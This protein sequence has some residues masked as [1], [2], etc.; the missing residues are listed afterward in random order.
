[1]KIN[2]RQISES[3]LKM[4]DKGGVYHGITEIVK[5]DPYLDMEMR[6]ST[7]VIVYYRGGKLLTID[8]E[9][10]LIGLDHNYYLADEDGIITPCIDNIFD[11]VSKAKFIIDKHE[12]VKPK[13]IEKEYQQ[14]V[15]Y[16]NNLSG[17]ANKTEY[18]IVDIEWEDSANLEGRADIVA[19]HWGRGRKDRI[20]RRLGLTLIEVKQGENAITTSDNSKSGK[21][22]PGLKK[23]Y[24][25][26]LKLKDD[27]VAVKELKND[28]FVVLKQKYK[29]GLLKGLDKLFQSGDKEVQPDITD[30][31]DFV[32]LLSNYHHFSSK[33]REE[34][35][36]LPDDCKF[37]IASF[38]GYGLYRDRI[39]TKKE[40]KSI[41]PKTFER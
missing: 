29:L 3:L 13:L 7:G 21:P 10:G 6:G 24:D 25:D 18:F 19:F 20:N 36:T 15:V 12:S 16:E 11:Y 1:M 34:C 27:A 9:D 31:F 2:K 32:F 30:D 39:Y 22:T 14:R 41:F 40:V 26:Y 5:V 8:E 35:E 23:H 38:M 4:L 17:N 37:F 28:M 33:L